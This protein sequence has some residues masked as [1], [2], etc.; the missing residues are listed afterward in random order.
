MMGTLVEKTGARGA[1]KRHCLA[2]LSVA[3]TRGPS[4][5]AAQNLW[6]PCAP[7]GDSLGICGTQDLVRGSPRIGI[8]KNL[9]PILGVLRMCLFNK[10][11]M[12]EISL[13]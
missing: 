11:S 5:L 1:G 6:I 3:A 4:R 13:S 12:S 2:A 7:G 8:G 9:L 10:E